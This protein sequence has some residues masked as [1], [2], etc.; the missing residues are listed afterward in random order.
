MPYV[1][2]YK[3]RFLRFKKL[4]RNHLS[5]MK[6]IGTHVPGSKRLSFF[7]WKARLE[8]FDFRCGYCLQQFPEENL[9][10]EHIVGIKEGG[11]H[12]IDN[13]IPACQLCNQTKGDKTL[14]DFQGLTREA[15]FARIHAHVATIKESI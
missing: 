7:E 4:T 5:R 1:S 3:K 15:L 11:Q 8:E 13:C 10:L 2:K 9:W 14:F 6:A 12:H